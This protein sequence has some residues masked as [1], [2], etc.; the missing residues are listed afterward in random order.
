MIKLKRL[1]VFIFSVT[2]I[3]SC[4]KDDPNSGGGGSIDRTANLKSL[5]TSAS[6]LL[7]DMTF[8]SLNIEMVYVEGNK[9]T[10]EGIAKFQ[11]FLE[12]RIY[13][14]DG[15]QINIRSVNSSG[16]APFAVEEIVE[17]EK[18]E[19]TAYNVGDEIAVY[20]YFAD[21][22]NEKDTNEKFVLGSAYRNTSM[23]IYEKTIREFASRPGAPNRATIEAA[24]L[25]HEFGHLFGLVDLG[26]TPVSNHEDPDNEG[27]CV[28]E[29]CLM[30]ASIEF[31]SGVI[32]LIDG[33]GV[34]NLDDACIEDL[35]SVGGK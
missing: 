34:P 29:G 13:K 25:N 27:H 12:S 35:Q 19:R 32:N 30:R 22:S 3:A 2:L 23:V 6:D 16:K 33:S 21:G 8:T 26:T 9:P 10:D 1:L 5:G 18:D 14:P 20:I 31:G 7:S 24:T 15:I 4:T 28:T 11:S 17:I